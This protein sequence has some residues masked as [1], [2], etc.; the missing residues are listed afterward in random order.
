MNAT[1]GGDR[2]PLLRFGLS[3]LPSLDW[4]RSS[5]RRNILGNTIISDKIFQNQ[6]RKYIFGK[7]QYATLIASLD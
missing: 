5:L 1:G 7:Y 2:R 6:T 3:V 4:I